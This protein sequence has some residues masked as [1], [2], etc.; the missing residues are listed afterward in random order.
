MD[1]VEQ[2]ALTV[3]EA[4]MQA[5]KGLKT[6]YILTSCKAYEPQQWTSRQNIPEGVIVVLTSYG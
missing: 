1:M 6:T 2:W 3:A 5:A 4:I